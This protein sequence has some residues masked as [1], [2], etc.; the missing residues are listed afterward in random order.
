MENHLP[1]SEE[2]EKFVK[3]KANVHIYLLFAQKI[4]KINI[5]SECCE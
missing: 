2:K 3:S 5:E 4:F 1:N